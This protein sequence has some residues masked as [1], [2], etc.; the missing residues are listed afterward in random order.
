MY[1]TPPALLILCARARAA[2]FPGRPA[3]HPPVWK[4]QPAPELG[5]RNT[6]RERTRTRD[7]Q[8][9]E[10]YKKRQMREETRGGGR[11][12]ERESR[13]DSTPTRIYLYIRTCA[14]A[15]QPR[16][17]DKVIVSFYDEE[18]GQGNM[19]DPN[20]GTLLLRCWLRASPP[21]IDSRRAAML[22]HHFRETERHVLRLV[23]SRGLVQHRIIRISGE[24]RENLCKN[25][26]I[27]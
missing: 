26:K 3:R 21:V 27:L 14:R 20:E 25:W 9:D 22:F 10:S 19:C 13:P 5:P 18:T 1:Y 17:T 23:F 11:R 2:L 16:K 12:G 8:T 7:R 6:T 15:R 24:E 4:A